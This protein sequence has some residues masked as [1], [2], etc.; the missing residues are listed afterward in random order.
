MVA[1]AS[2]GPRVRVA[3]VILVGSRLLLVRQ[4]MSGEPYYLL[5][6]GGVDHGETLEQALRREVLEETGLECVIGE[7]LFIN[8]TI[9][10]DGHRHLVNITFH[11]E[12]TGG[13]LLRSPLDPSIE[14]VELIEP[15]EILNL[16]LRPPIA[17]DL[18][19]AI[20]SGFRTPAQYLGPVWTD[21][22]T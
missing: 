18:L 21:E 6:G 19:A 11:S 2:D 9:A 8:D 5:P 17:V 10:P 7:P 20:S 13:A 3:A 1:P 14:G 15:A 22:Q 16:D 4:R 12:M